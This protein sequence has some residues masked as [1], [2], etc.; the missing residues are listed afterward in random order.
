MATDAEFRA[1]ATF[2]TTDPARLGWNATIGDD[3]VAIHMSSR[4]WG[5]NARNC[6]THYIGYE[7]A[8]ATEADPISDAQVRAFCWL[9]QQD[10]AVWPAMP[11][12]LKTHAEVDGT[13]E[14]GPFLDGKTDVFHRG[15]PSADDLKAR[16]VARL[17]ELGVT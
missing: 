5:W 12:V 17:A 4:Q 6:S 7:F 8:Q 1:T 10:R 11:L 2:A 3:I 13:P 15:S 9:V 14:Y 16:I